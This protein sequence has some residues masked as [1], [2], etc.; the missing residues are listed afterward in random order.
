MLPDKGQFSSV[1]RQ[2]WFGFRWAGLAD[3]PGVSACY[4]HG[5]CSPETAVTAAK[6]YRGHSQRHHLPK[7]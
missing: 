4:I 5:S 6:S 7:V 3:Q 2:S 1:V